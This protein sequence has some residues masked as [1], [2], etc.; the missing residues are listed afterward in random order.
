[1][2]KKFHIGFGHYSDYIEARASYD[3][4]RQVFCS[5]RGESHADA[6]DSLYKELDKRLKK[7]QEEHAA[8]MSAV[9]ERLKDRHLERLEK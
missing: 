6:L 1:M 5:A 7:H 9:F 8:A 4:T 3:D 2:K